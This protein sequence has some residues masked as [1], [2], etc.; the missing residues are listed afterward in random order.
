MTDLAVFL[1]SE[2]SSKFEF[3][4]ILDEAQRVYD[5]SK[6]WATLTVPKA[7][8]LF[9]V[10]AGSYGSHTGS[11]AHSPPR[12]YISESRRINLFPSGEDDTL[13]VAFKESDFDEFLGLA[14]NTTGCASLDVNLR[15]RILNYASPY[16][17]NNTCQKLLHPGVAVELTV[18]LLSKVCCVLPYELLSSKLCST[19]EKARNY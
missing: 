10:A 7:Q 5:N 11:A 3:W 6:L 4:I 8:Q 12:Q 18:Y 17:A 16:P 13:C 1:Q 9:V 14:L 19:V 15:E 2:S